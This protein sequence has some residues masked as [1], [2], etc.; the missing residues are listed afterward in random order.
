MS[1]KPALRYVPGL[2]LGDIMANVGDYLNIFVSAE[3]ATS[4]Y[5]SSMA[6]K[7]YGRRPYAPISDL[8]A[9]ICHMGILF[10]G[11]D[12]PKRLAPNIVLTSP[13][14]LQFTADDISTS[15]RRIDEDCTFHG[16]VVTVLARP[17]LDVYPSVRSFASVS[18]EFSGE[19]N[20]SVDIVDF[21][22]VP[23]FE[24]IP[25]C[26]DRPNDCVMHSDDYEL[27]VRDE[28][29][30]TK[31]EVVFPYSKGLF[32]SESVGYLLKDFVIEFRC[33]HSAYQLR[34][35][36]GKVTLKK[37]WQKN[38]EVQTEDVGG[39]LDANNMYIGDDRVEIGSVD[40]GPIEQVALFRV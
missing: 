27:L 24:S 28:L 5:I 25:N 4:E 33:E 23:E 39:A 21:Y 18:G 13:G 11:T 31:E 8:I 1:G 6:D 32:S 29:S 7:A 16:I 35:S 26:S 38:K 20:F 34:E 14:A 19:T 30:G 2:A 37:T 22:F 9:I 3:Y 12:K 15:E 17:P 40:V 10:P 36:D